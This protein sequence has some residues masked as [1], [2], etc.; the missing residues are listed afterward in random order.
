MQGPTAIWNLG[1]IAITVVVSYRGLMYPSLMDQYL[2]E[3]ARILRDKEYYRL[4]TSGFLHADGIHLLFNMY[5]LYAFGRYI[6]EYV[7][8]KTF[9]L[10][11]F[12]GIIGGNLLSLYLHRHHEYR[13]LGASGGVCGVI[14]ASIFLLPGGSIILFMLPVPMPSWV[15]AIAFLLFSFYGMRKQLGNIGHDAHLGGAIV[16]LLVATA[17]HPSIVRASPYLYAAVMA[18]TA[19]LLVFCLKWPMYLPGGMRQFIRRPRQGQK[20]NASKRQADQKELDRLLD[21]VSKSGLH[22]LSWRERR[23]LKTISKRLDRN[24]F[25]L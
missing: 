11:Y 8:I 1:I 14:Y 7:G 15:Y 6:E 5:S 9:L 18:I 20:Q 19:G 25:D 12:S 23:K 16:G 10:I 24:S 3:P 2:F 21:K 22:S 4:V 17:L 13:A